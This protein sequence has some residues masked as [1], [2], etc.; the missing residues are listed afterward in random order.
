MQKTLAWGSQRRRGR[1]ST[2]RGLG[3]SGRSR[4]GAGEEPEECGEGSEQEPGR[5]AHLGRSSGRN[6]WKDCPGPSLPLR[7]ARR[8]QGWKP[9][10]GDLGLGRGEARGTPSLRPQLGRQPSAKG[11]GH[12]ASA[13]RATP[14][15]GVS[16]GAASPAPLPV[17]ARAGPGSRRPEALGPPGTRVRPA[18]ETRRVTRER[19]PRMLPG[20]EGSAQG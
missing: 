2:G 18:G 16:S 4:R 8:G 20:G 5:S 7:A 19:G 3:V 1:R 6:P 17:P 10:A 15:P 11:R 9:E 14:V 13:T 12:A